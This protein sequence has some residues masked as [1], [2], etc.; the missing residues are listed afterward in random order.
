M[1]SG[2]VSDGLER[3]FSCTSIKNNS[4]T[5]GH[6]I[7]PTIDPPKA[8]WKWSHINSIVRDMIEHYTH[9]KQLYPFNIQ[10][11]I[12]ILMLCH[13]TGQKS[14]IQYDKNIIGNTWILVI[15]TFFKQNFFFY[16]RANEPRKGKFAIFFYVIKIWNWYFFC[17]I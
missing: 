2:L 7:H 14:N 4:Q 8:K 10:T 12:R 13:G 16:S 15:D 3:A 9:V 5:D 11:K 6:Q 1:G 17:K